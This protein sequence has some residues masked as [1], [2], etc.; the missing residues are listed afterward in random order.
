M[1]INFAHRIGGQLSAYCAVGGRECLC[2][3][4]FWHPVMSYELRPANIM[5]IIDAIRLEARD[6]EPVGGDS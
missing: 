5:R 6:H 1:K 3:S 4:R 2:S